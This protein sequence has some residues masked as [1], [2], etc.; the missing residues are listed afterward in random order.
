MM[1]MFC[2]LSGDWS[3]FGY[4]TL[5]EGQLPPPTININALGKESISLSLVSVRDFVVPGGSQYAIYGLPKQSNENITVMIRMEKRQQPPVEINDQITDAVT[6][7]P[8]EQE[9]VEEQQVDIQSQENLT[10]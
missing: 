7:P 4:E 5:Y 10:T 1:K 3:D 8:V 9:V 6:T 2:E